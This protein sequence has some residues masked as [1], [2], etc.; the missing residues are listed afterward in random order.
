MRHSEIAI[1]EA[2]VEHAERAG[3]LV[4][5]CVYA[6]RKGSPDRWFFKDG[7]LVLVEFKRRGEAPNPQQDREH[8]RLR[9]AGFPVHVIDSIEAGYALFG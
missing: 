7:K 3:W 1:E 2:V 8:G 5:K 9:A 6:G 4:R